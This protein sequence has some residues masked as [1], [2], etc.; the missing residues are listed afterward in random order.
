MTREGWEDI[1]RKAI[2]SHKYEVVEI[3][4]ETRSK[5]DIIKIFI[6]SDSGIT[7][8]DCTAVSQLV[9]DV[10]F[11]LN[12]FPGNYRLEVSSPGVN[13]PLKTMKDF[14]KNIN[15]QMLVTVLE[16]EKHN[17]YQGT[18]TSVDE[19]E[20]ILREKKNEVKIP[21][22]TVIEGRIVLPW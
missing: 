19:K 22:N 17:Y 13:R 11:A 14:V 7:L 21:L 12:A 20:L 9:K 6:D 4:K 1:V 15:R 5:L 8:D 2:E 3:R 10:L 18:L 16:N